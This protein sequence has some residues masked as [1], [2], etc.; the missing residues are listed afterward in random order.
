[1][2]ILGIEEEIQEGDGEKIINR[3]ETTLTC[4]IAIRCGTCSSSGR[5]I[6]STVR[7]SLGC[8]C[9]IPSYT[10]RDT[11]IPAPSLWGKYCDSSSG[12]DVSM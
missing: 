2:I 8:A 7:T 3:T 5:M 1:M 10:S 4:D 9:L 12:R 11:K 6:S